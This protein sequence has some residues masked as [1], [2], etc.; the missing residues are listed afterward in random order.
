MSTTEG[1]SLLGFLD[2]PIVVGDPEGRVIFVNPAFERRFCRG[3]KSPQG[4]P[5]ATLFAGGGREAM[6]A[7]V[8]EVCSK[9]ESVKFRL[10][11]DGAGYLAVASPIE[12]A[13]DRVGVVILLTDEPLM[14]GRLLDFHREIHE[15]LEESMSVM[16]ELLE[17]TGGRRDDRYKSLLERGSNAIERARK[18]SEE[19]HGL[20][21]GGAKTGSGEETLVA[22]RVLRQVAGRLAPELDRAGVSLE[23]LLPTQLPVVRGD[24]TLLETALVRL[25]RQRLSETPP[26]SI[27]NL[28][29]RLL[30]TGQARCI[31]FSVVDPCRGA[32]GQELS[33]E[34]RG[35]SEPRLVGEIIG[36]LGGQLETVVEPSLGRVTA[37]R[38][39]VVN[40]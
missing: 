35:E 39:A 21:C 34:S 29:T 26:G 5:L 8:A 32:D 6:L 22:I 28:T 40:D 27:I 15:P 23:L 17:Q 38:L 24:A 12:A 10:R 4:D 3:G 11:E 7:S 19:L 31:L 16:E 20:L 36:V 2:A 14:D 13:D 9:G 37:I 33:T 1:Q 30:G 25:V 18:W